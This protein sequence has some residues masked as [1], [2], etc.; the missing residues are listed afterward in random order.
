MYPYINKYCAYAY[1]HPNIIKG[2]DD[3]SKIN[4]K[5]SSGVI[6]CSIFAPSYI[7]QPVL[8]VRGTCIKCMNGYLP[9]C[10]HTD[11]ERMLTGTWVIE[12]VNLAIE[13]GYRIKTV[14][15]LW[16]FKTEQYNP[17]TRTGGIFTEYMNVFIKLKE[18]ALMTEDEKTAYIQEFYEKEGVI[19]DKDNIIPNPSYRQISKICLNSLWGKLLDKS[20]RSQTSNFIEKFYILFRLMTQL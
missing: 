18:E 10:N 15:E 1:G 16:L 19:L 2:H 14:Y 7:S 3:C 8:P 11:D 20:L 13:V 4:L 9:I 12:E 17:I 6:K 5:A